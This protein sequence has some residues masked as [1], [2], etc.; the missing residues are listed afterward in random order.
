MAELSGKVKSW[1]CEQGYPVEMH[2]AKKFREAGFRTTQSEYFVDPESRDNREIDVVASCQKDIGVLLVRITVCVECKSSKKHPWVA[3]TSKD[4]RLSRSASIVQRPA[5]NLG[6]EFLRRITQNKYAH[7]IPFFKMGE[8]NGF[9]LTE[10]F[11]SG[12]D[13]AYAA[14]LSVAKCARSLVEKAEEGSRLQGPICNI[15][16]PLVVIDGKLF[17]CHQDDLEIDVEEINQATL[18]WRNQVSNTG[19][20]IIGIC[21][22]DALS[23]YIRGV[24]RLANFVFAQEDVFQDIEN[25]SLAEYRNRWKHPLITKGSSGSI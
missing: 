2:V 19:H 4:T 1:I 8:R 16:I 9:S 6:K 18:I 3:F 14:C 24:S 10:A 25:E 23:K 21:T 20:S 7:Q 22:F 13:N 11:T 17:E 5:N 15:V 12:K